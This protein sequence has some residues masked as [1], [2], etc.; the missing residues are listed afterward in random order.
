[1]EKDAMHKVANTRCKVNGRYEV[2]IP[3]ISD[4]IDNN[5]SVALQRLESLGR[6][7]RRH[8]DVPEGCNKVL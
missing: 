5:K 8:P 3:W 2:G 7:L 6:S 1:M 4:H